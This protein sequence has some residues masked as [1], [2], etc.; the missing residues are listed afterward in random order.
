MLTTLFV[1]WAHGPAR[2]QQFLNHLNSVRHSTNFTMEVKAND[3]LLFL[4]VLFMKRGPKL[5]I[6][7]YHKLT[8]T[9]RYLHFKS[10]HSHH[11][12]RG[13]IHR[14]ISRAKAVCQDQED[15]NNEI[16]NIQIQ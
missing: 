2:W 9:G 13:V 14:L 15:F 10:N 6:K 16:K 1:V 3:T 7:L 4:G 11:V 5:A 8:H 12:K